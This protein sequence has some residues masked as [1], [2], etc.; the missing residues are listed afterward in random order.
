[1]NLALKG[2]EQDHKSRYCTYVSANHFIKE[3]E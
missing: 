1:M 3:T 2:T